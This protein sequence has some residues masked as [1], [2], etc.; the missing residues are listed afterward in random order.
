MKRGLILV[1][2]CKISVITCTESCSVNQSAELVCLSFVYLLYLFLRLQLNCRSHF[3]IRVLVL[4]RK[5][6]ISPD[7]ILS[8]DK[9][10]SAAKRK[11]YSVRIVN[12]IYVISC[13][14][15]A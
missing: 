10:V 13:R 3:Y 2:M 7:D 14:I 6:A 11:R 9:L 5:R 4:R 12:I 1:C 8:D 15:T